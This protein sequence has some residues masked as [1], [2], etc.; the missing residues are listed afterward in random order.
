VWPATGQR[1]GGG[2]NSA[3]DKEPRPAPITR[4]DLRKLVKK[5]PIQRS[6]A[7]AHGIKS[8]HGNSGAIQNEH[9]KQKDMSI[10]GK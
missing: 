7:E 3:H 9:K 2:R 1:H 10:L 4:L 6:S 8:W 5:Q